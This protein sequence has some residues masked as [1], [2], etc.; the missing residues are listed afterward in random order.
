MS[1]HLDPALFARAIVLESAEI[2]AEMTI[3]QWRRHKQ[4]ALR[5]ERAGRQAGHRWRR[6]SRRGSSNR[7]VAS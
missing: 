4:A 3:A 6:R 7:P 1:T 2:P 5:E